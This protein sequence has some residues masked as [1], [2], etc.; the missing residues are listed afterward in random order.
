[1]FLVKWRNRQKKYNMRVLTGL[2]RFPS[3]QKAEKQVK[4]WLGLFPFNTYYVEPA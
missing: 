3:K 1:M 2:S 4:V